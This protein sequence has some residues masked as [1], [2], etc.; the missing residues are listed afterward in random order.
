MVAFP[1]RDNSTRAR[2]NARACVD[3]KPKLGGIAVESAK[4][5]ARINDAGPLNRREIGA[6]LSMTGE[7]RSC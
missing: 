5:G 3:R 1:C 6:S 7:F 4:D 2:A